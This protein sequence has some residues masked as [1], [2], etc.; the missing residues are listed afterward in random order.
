MTEQDRIDVAGG[1]PYIPS[2]NVDFSQ[3]DH[4]D[5][6]AR[7][8]DDRIHR[9]ENW[10]ENNFWPVWE[11]TWESY[12]GFR[13]PIVLNDPTMAA[14]GTL[15][16]AFAS[17]SVAI[18]RAASNRV[19]RQD[20][21]DGLPVLWNACQRVVAR[22][23]ANVP[24]ITCRSHDP[25]RADR[26]SA[27]YMYFY[28]KAQRKSRVVNKTLTSTWIT[29]WGPN[30]WGWDDTTIKRVRL[31][32][33][34]RMTDDM[35]T[36]VLETYKPQLATI[37]EDIVTAAGIDPNDE[38]AMD[39]ASLQA[40][41][42]LAQQYGHKGRLR[43]IYDERGYVG[44]SVK[45]TFPGD[46]F[47]EP[48]FDTLSTCAYVG[49][50]M[51]V[52]IE[53]FQEL[54]ERH[55]LPDGNYDPELGTRI[56]RV[57]DE[58]PHGDV[59]AIGSQ[60]ERL[61]GNLYN[62]IK[63]STSNNPS[64]EGTNADDMEVR[65]GVH[66]IEYPGR[67]GEDATV[68]YKCGNIWLGH[69]YYPFLIGDGKVA[70]TE[71]R[72]VESI[73]GGIGESPAHHIV[74]LADMYAQSFFQRHDLIDAIS[75]PLLWTDDAALWSNPEFFTRNTSG[76]RVVYTRGGGKSFGFEQ[77]GPAIASALSSMNSDESAMKLIQ[78]TTGDSNLGNMAEL[79][80]GQNNTATGAKIMD[81]NT[82][83]LSGQT[84]SMFVQKIGEDCEMM[85][86]LL[87]S[88]LNEDLALDLGQYHMLSGQSAKLQEVDES[89]VT[90]EPEDY[91]DDGEIIIDSTSI[92]PDAKQNKVNEANL[93]YGLAKENPDKMHIDECIK[94]V[95]KAM[96]KG[97]DISRIMI[98]PP[99]PGSEEAN[100]QANPMEALKG[101]L[102]GKG[103]PPN[104]Q[105]NAAPNQPGGPPQGPANTNP[106]S[107]VPAGGAA[108][109]AN[110][111]PATS[112]PGT[113]APE[114]EGQQASHGGV[115]LM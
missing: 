85:R 9:S 81:R 41:P 78:S 22:V 15:D 61:R 48:E 115:P 25:A 80:P 87:R 94:D 42:V 5:D 57:M 24:I 45:Y 1:G 28:D 70:R 72:I 31:V 113:A 83:I 2:G 89:M 55:K 100:A 37:I 84:T 30:S 99:P 73:L 53:W 47:P 4:D 10:L 102:Q 79:T 104:G 67:G 69:F 103:G 71:L 16:G 101:A 97:K 82:A 58:K 60:S 112:V 66:K 35:I 107:P 105:A 77:S 17:D 51:R 92:F 20:R 13:K 88:E 114:L 54:Y 40:I 46:I 93:I 43:L 90:M 38:E 12:S 64:N 59:R 110:G 8:M 11:R 62:L 49:E 33:P 27:S 18:L 74:S 3:G 36:A 106:T 65:W 7:N 21:T 111:V 14:P 95:L 76:F 26:L 96:G 75:R 56:Q 29:G 63:R 52:G 44:P 108:G 6:R 39:D 86:E 68:E 98:P 50:Y 34:E 23:N 19:Q 109:N 91:E 32:R